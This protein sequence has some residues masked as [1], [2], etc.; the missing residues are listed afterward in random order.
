VMGVVSPASAL[1]TAWEFAHPF[2]V[3]ENAGF[4]WNGS[5]V[6]EIWDLATSTPMLPLTILLVPVAIYWVLSILGAVDHDHFGG[7]D[8]DG[9]ID[10]QH[11]GGGGDGHSHSGDGH[12]LGEVMHGALRMLNAQGVP[13]MMVLSVLVAYLWGC[14]MLGN[15]WFNK[16]LSG[17]TGT[18]VS[19]GALV[20]AIILTRLTVTPLKPLFRLIQDDP[21]PQ[22]PVLGR[23]GVVRTA[24]VNEREG[25]VEVENAGA[26]LLLNA[27]I[28]AGSPPLS[29]GTSVLVIR[30]DDSTGL[31]IVRSLTESS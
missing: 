19:I 20:V 18:L 14:S 6:K 7:V 17:S 12:P 15:L 2:I 24:Q 30:Y 10:A 22:K 25:Q 29:R 21:E 5:V 26:P 1:T 9:S 4:R 3:A 27:R 23:T 31:Y 11:H 28:A 16:A 8:L 13:L